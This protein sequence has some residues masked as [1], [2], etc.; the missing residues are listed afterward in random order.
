[1]LVNKI[2]MIPCPCG[3]N[4]FPT[5]TCSSF[6]ISVTA[7]D[8]RY[9]KEDA[10]RLVA[11]WNLLRHLSQEEL[12]NKLFLIEKSNQTSSTTIEESADRNSKAFHSIRSKD[13][14]FPI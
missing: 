11:S 3:E 8:G 14:R 12:D 5:R 13:G 10:L 7:S 1:M 2:E 6:L 9:S 4:I